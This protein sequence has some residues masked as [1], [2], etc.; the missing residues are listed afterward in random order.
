[1]ARK[2]WITSSDQDCA[3]ALISIPKMAFGLKRRLTGTPVTTAM[4]CGPELPDTC[5]RRSSFPCRPA[6]C[7]VILVAYSQRCPERPTALPP[8][9]SY[10]PAL[11][12]KLATAMLLLTYPVAD[13]RE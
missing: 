8:N 3:V 10:I 12:V 2:G 9:P 7:I 5:T 4:I 1:M 6:A 13:A 11:H